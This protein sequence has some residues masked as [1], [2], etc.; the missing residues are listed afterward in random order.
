MRSFIILGALVIVAGCNSTIPLG[1]PTD[2]LRGAVQVLNEATD[3]QSRVVFTISGGYSGPTTLTIPT[4]DALLELKSTGTRA[5]IERLDVP[6]G[7]IKIPAQALPPSGL[8]LRNLSLDLDDVPATTVQ[9]SDDT[10]SFHSEAPLVLEWSLQLEDGSLYPLAPTPTDP[11][12]IDVTVT[13]NA[14]DMALRFVATCKG[15]CWSDRGVAQLSNG[16][17]ILDAGARLVQ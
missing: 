11:M 8:Q 13:R 6:L 5:T 12:P 10:L 1:P 7:D 16:S 4:H 2:S 3:A 9:A 15:T 14:G 17:V